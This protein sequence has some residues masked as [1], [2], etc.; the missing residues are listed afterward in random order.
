MSQQNAIYLR[1]LSVKSVNATAGEWFYPAAVSIRFLRNLLHLPY[2]KHKVILFVISVTCFQNICSIL[3][4]KQTEDVAIPSCLSLSSSPR[5][6]SPRTAVSKLQ[7]KS[8][9][10]KSARSAKV[11]FL[12]CPSSFLLLP[13]PKEKQPQTR[14]TMVSSRAQGSQASTQ[15]PNKHYFCYVNALASFLRR[16][17]GTIKGDN[18]LLKIGL[19]KPENH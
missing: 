12:G 9:Q 2:L 14:K 11:V 13:A 17:S 18:P 1:K 19:L 16:W 5:V 7:W 3:Y 4:F 6:S 8:Q 10:S 15:T